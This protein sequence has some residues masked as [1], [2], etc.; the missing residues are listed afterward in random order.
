MNLWLL[1]YVHSFNTQCRV[2]HF[3]YVHSLQKICCVHLFKGQLQK[4]FN[5]S[6]MWADLRELK[7]TLKIIKSNLQAIFQNTYMNKTFLAI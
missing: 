1:A 6:K 2:Y 5:L 3:P 7:Q 4:A